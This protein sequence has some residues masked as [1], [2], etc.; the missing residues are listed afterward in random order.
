MMDTRGVGESVGIGVK[1]MLDALVS[2][3]ALV[4]RG[5]V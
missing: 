4:K 5:W 1:E 2:G 3:G